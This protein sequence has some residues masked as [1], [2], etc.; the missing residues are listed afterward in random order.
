MHTLFVLTVE[1]GY[2]QAVCIYR[3]VARAAAV[4]AEGENESKPEVPKQDKPAEVPVEAPAA[5][6]ETKSGGLQPGQGTAI[7]TGAISLILGIG[8]IALTILLDSRGE[9]LPPPPEAFLQ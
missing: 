8:Y 3:G 6:E 5:S 2:F 4:R 9:L 1:V 7:V